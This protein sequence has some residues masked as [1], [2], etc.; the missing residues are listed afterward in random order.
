[1]VANL[2][3]FSQ[4]TYDN[5]LLLVPD[6]TYAAYAQSYAWDCFDNIQKAAAVDGIAADEDSL[7]VVYYNLQGVK[8]E[9]PQGGIFIRCQGAKIE[10]ITL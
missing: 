5:A 10:K 1:T 3:A 7:P 4:E 8:I 6:D 9:N 2:N